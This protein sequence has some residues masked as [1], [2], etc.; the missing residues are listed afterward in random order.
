MTGCLGM[1]SWAHNSPKWGSRTRKIWT[2]SF[3]YTMHPYQSNYAIKIN[4]SK[5]FA[6]DY[7]STLTRMSKYDFECQIRIFGLRAN[8][9]LES[10]MSKYDF[11]TQCD[12][13]NRPLNVRIE[14]SDS[15]RVSKQDSPTACKSQNKVVNV[16]IGFFAS[17]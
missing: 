6:R 5:K 11:P 14:F 17:V 3:S 12:C 9:K 16:K 13:Q 15:V 8:V 1:G 7:I 4:F 2:P 10:G